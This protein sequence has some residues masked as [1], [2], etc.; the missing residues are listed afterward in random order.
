MVGDTIVCFPY[1]A[2]SIV[3]VNTVTMAISRALERSYNLYLPIFQTLQVSPDVAIALPYTKVGVIV[4]AS[5]PGRVRAAVFSNDGS[6]VVTADDKRGLALQKN[7]TANNALIGVEPAPPDGLSSGA[8]TAHSLAFSH[9]GNVLA[10]GLR[11]PS[12]MQLAVALYDTSDLTKPP[13]LTKVDPSTAT[14][15]VTF[16]ESM[17]LIIKCRE[18]PPCPPHLCNRL[19]IHLRKLQAT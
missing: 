13:V 2:R 12:A 7:A 8:G 4:R 16:P 17:A 14:F 3:F 11:A 1:Y 9:Q 19:S 10:V 18:R 5:S 15:L 6:V